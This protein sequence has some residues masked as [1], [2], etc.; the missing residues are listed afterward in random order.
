M[1][2]PKCGY[3]SFDYLQNCKKCGADFTE[4]KTRYNLRSILFPNAPVKPAPKAELAAGKNDPP[5]TEA[6]PPGSFFFDPAEV[7]DTGADVAALDGG[8]L[9]G[10]ADPADPFEEP[11]AFSLESLL[12]TVT[13]R[14]ELVEPPETEPLAETPAGTGQFTTWEDEPAADFAAE[15][16]LPLHPLEGSLDSA[17]QP[18]R[19]ESSDFIGCDEAVQV[20]EEEAA[21]PVFPPESPLVQPSFE[22]SAI[23]E[24]AAGPAAA[25]A[26]LVEEEKTDEDPF[27]I[28]L[29]DFDRLEPEG[30]ELNRFGSQNSISALEGDFTAPAEWFANVDAAPALEESPQA[31][32]ALELDAFEADGSELPFSPALP[33]PVAAR[34]AASAIDL[35]ILAGIFALFLLAGELAV[36]PAGSTSTRPLTAALLEQ[37]IPYFLVLFFLGF[38]YSTFFHFLLG[39]TPGKMLLRLRVETTTGDPVTF[40]RAFLRSTGGLLSLLTGGLGFLPSLRR[41]GRG[42]ND[43]LAGTRV[44]LAGSGPAT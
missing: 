25:G 3:T 15:S 27:R 19:S 2:C 28:N 23:A 20:R 8:P 9:F 6:D 33:A 21:G 5:L 35:L 38:G 44:V 41:E 43:R 4:V 36:Q 32:D 24:V 11:G 40:S 29:E 17:P 31:Q 10:S 1:K 14:S 42:L 22:F 34:V 13:V 37:A 16:A 26:A 30:E 12:E 39:Q 18:P 7:N